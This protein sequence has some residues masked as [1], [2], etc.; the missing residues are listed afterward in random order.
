MKKA[1]SGRDALDSKIRELELLQSEQIEDLKQSGQEFMHSMSPSNLLKNAMKT[2]VGSPGLRSTAIDTAISAGA[3]LLG[4]KLFV[5]NSK[6]VFR[7]LAGTAV[8]FIVSNF[9]RNKI[10]EVKEKITGHHI[11]GV[12]K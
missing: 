3:G 1:V 12:E 7:K 9:V 2:V 6:S 11:N 8:Q 5:F 10:P 4:K